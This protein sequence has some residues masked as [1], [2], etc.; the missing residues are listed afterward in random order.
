MVRD[1]AHRVPYVDEAGVVSPFVEQRQ[2]S[3]RELV[4]L[5]HSV[6]EVEPVAASNRAGESVAGRVPGERG[7]L[8]RPVGDRCSLLRVV[9]ASLSEVELEMNVEPQPSRQCERALK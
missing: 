5:V 8:S 2:S 1:L 9:P 7:A 3:T 4:Q 6:L